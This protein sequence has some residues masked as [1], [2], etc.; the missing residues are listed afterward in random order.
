M[1]STARAASIGRQQPLLAR[2]ALRAARGARLA[3]TAA[4][5]TSAAAGPTIV[6]GQILHNVSKEK[7]DLINGMGDFAEAQV[8]LR[9]LKHTATLL[10]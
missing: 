2:P 4:A 7:L 3:P 1:A 10:T 8:L 6:N 9:G 5:S